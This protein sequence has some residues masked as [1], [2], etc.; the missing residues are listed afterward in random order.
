[1]K[2]HHIRSKLRFH[3]HEDSCIQNDFSVLIDL[4]IIYTG[5]GKYCTVCY[6]HTRYKQCLSVAVTAQQKNND[7]TLVDLF[8]FL[9][10]IYSCCFLHFQLEKA[11]SD[12]R[13]IEW[14][15]EG[16]TIYLLQVNNYANF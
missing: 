9:F 14:A 3:L 6:Q 15:V 8:L 13:D 12:P 7:N 4:F 5:G 10:H 1:M 11:F 16:E 2:Y